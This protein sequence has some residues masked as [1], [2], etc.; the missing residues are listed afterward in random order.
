MTE[1]SNTI[2][3]SPPRLTGLTLS[4]WIHA[5]ALAA[6]AHAQ[7]YGRWA[8]PQ[9]MYQESF[10]SN[11]GMWVLSLALGATLGA[12]F[13]ERA[14]PL[15]RFLW[16]VAATALAV[17]FALTSSTLLSAELFIVGFAIAYALLR[18]PRMPLGRDT[19][20]GS[21]E[22]ATLAHLQEND[23]IG[24]EGFFLGSFD[25]DGQ[26]HPLRYTGDRHLLTI[27]PTR[28][29]KGT[30]AIIPNLLSYTGSALVIDPK[31][32]NARITSLRRGDGNASIPGLKQKVHVVDPWG[33]TDLPPSRF[34]PLDWIAAD[35]ANSSENAMIL[36]DSIVTPREGNGD[37]FWDDEAKA[38]LMGV[39]L[40][41]AFDP[42]EAERRTLGRVRDVII[43]DTDQL[44]EILGCMAVSHNP[45]VQSTAAR[46]I[47]KEDKLRQGVLASLQSHTHFLDSPAV[48]KSL[49]YSD[50][51]FEDLKAS[52]MTVYLFL[53]ADRL[54]TFSRWLRLLVQQA[55]T[56]NARNV[57]TIPE[58]PILFLL[59]ELPA[60]GRLTM[61]AQ[62]YSL[63]AGFGMQ[64]WGI[65]QD[66][67]QLERIYGKG[68]QSF[69]ANSGVLQSFGSRDRATA[70]YFSSLCGVTTM[71]K[72]S[73]SNTIARVF[74]STTGGANGAGSSTTGTTASNGYTRDVVQRKLAYPDELMVLR[75][76]RQIVFI[77]NSNPIRGRKL[78]WFNDPKRKD[79]GVNLHKTKRRGVAPA[80][81]AVHDGIRVPLEPTFAEMFAQL[82]GVKER[83]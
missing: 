22:W 8:S 80:P 79:L 68:W 34:N 1:T 19:T 14:K 44:A 77:E 24:E 32:E 43:S 56:V 36:A 50:F 57:E 26:A 25:A 10:W 27:A 69:V 21:A 7:N 31:G 60:L 61:V 33:I 59:D 82:F 16:L 71:E 18:L 6:A 64:L 40:Y 30:S 62:A 54:A 73:F 20:F 78:S 38:L 42:A 35:E 3:N 41:V 81:A 28:S 15:R 72:L 47:S 9:P 49:S 17:A 67:S 29:G 52:K 2:S 5:F 45:I 37:P 70:E 55:I 46:T 51:Q 12:F 48:R 66:V 13:S 53:P 23:W 76:G 74:S 75:N 4:A 65:V 63:M 58:K 11:L 39:I 83:A